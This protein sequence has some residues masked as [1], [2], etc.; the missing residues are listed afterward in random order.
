MTLYDVVKKEL[1]LVPMECKNKQEAL[2]ALV[3]LLA[4]Q[5]KINK[6]Q[7]LKSVLDR[8]KLGSTAIGNGV[9]IPHC[10]STLINETSL[11]VGVSPRMI[12]YD[13]NE[14]RLF[15]LVV[16]PENKSSEHVQILSSIAR[17]CS[18]SVNRNLLASAK[19]VEV[20]F[21]AIDN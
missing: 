19:T 13:D 14:V 15:F 2:E 11:V 10:K 4:K 18:S 9:A 7:L 6:D 1:I 5:K 3:E 12:E 17:Y 8:E 20:A 21:S 16:A